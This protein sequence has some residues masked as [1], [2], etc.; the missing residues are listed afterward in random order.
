MSVTATGALL[1]VCLAALSLVLRP[2]WLSGAIPS[3]AQHI[4]ENGDSYWQQMRRNMSPAEF[5]KTLDMLREIDPERYLPNARAPVLVQCAR[6]DIDDN[7][8]G[9]PA[10][11]EKAGGPK[12][13]VW[14]DDDHHFTS[15]EALRDR[16]AWLEK[17]L[18]LQALDPHVSKFLKEVDASGLRAVCGRRLHHS[19][20]V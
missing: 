15:L 8:R 10:V 12:R 6:F 5:A 9:C 3:Y 2:S 1:A 4:Q 11:Y 16:L 19:H 14:Y 20:P 18:R 7:V 13:L 17:Y